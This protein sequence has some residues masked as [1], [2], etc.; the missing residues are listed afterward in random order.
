MVLENRTEGL[1]YLIFLEFQ[2]HS[3]PNFGHLLLTSLL[4]SQN[5]YF[6]F[7]FGINFGKKKKFIKTGDPIVAITGWRQG[8]GSSNTVRILYVE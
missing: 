1:E 3:P 7:Q 4:Y 2:P 5:F 8:A 6:L